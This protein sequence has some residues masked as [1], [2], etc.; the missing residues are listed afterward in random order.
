MRLRWVSAEE[1]E[2][3]GAGK[4]LSGVDGIVV[5]IGWGKR[6]RRVKISAINYARINKIPFLGLCYGMQ[7]ACIEFSRN[8]VGLKDANTTENDPETSNPII[9]DIPEKGGVDDYKKPWS[10]D[11]TGRMG[12]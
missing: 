6:G 10:G 12:F 8:V 1:V 4:L 11:E 3:N 2:E 9:H 7:L 5:P